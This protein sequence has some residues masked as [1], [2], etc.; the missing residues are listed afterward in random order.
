MTGMLMEPRA[1]KEL[2][3]TRVEDLRAARMGR[4]ANGRLPRRN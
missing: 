3:D 1:L 4:R 2:I